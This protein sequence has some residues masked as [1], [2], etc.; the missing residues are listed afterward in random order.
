MQV[1]FTRNYR[2]SYGAGQAG[3]VVDLDEE[4]VA[5][6]NRDSPGTLMPVAAARDVA[7]PVETRQVTAPA[8]RRGRVIG[9]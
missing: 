7:A 3:D 8:G 1:R 6:I 2:S 5:A 9:G 4:L